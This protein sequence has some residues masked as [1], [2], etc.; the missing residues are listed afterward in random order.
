MDALKPVLCMVLV[1]PDHPNMN[2]MLGII[3]SGNI[4]LLL[5]ELLRNRKQN[6]E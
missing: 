5:K 4:L 1:D 6:V 2:N 3:Q